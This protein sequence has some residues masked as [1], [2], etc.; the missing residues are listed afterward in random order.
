MLLK[1][2]STGPRLALKSDPTNPSFGEKRTAVL[3]SDPSHQSLGKINDRR[4]KAA[5]P[6]FQIGPKQSLF[7]KEMKEE[8]AVENS[9]TNGIYQL[10]FSQVILKLWPILRKHQ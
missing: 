3:K 9:I 5:V 1:N 7:G 4:K 10:E 8:I 6:R 2:W